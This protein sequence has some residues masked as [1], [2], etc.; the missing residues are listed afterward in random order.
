MKHSFQAFQASLILFPVRRAPNADRDS[1]TDN[2]LIILVVEGE[3]KKGN[4]VGKKSQAALLAEIML[5]YDAL[6]SAST[7]EENRQVM[8]ARL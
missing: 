8:S 4:E 6:M 1:I 3:I 2:D 5:R 7:N